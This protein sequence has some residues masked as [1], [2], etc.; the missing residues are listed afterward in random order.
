M[1]TSRILAAGMLFLILTSFKSDKLPKTFQKLLDRAGMMF[2]MPE[3]FEETKPIDNVQMNY[4]YALK[5]PGKKLEVRYAVRP[6][7]NF[8]KEYEEFQE[9]KKEGDMMISPNK[10]YNSLMQATL[11]NISGGQLPQI[12]PFDKDAVKEEFNADWGATAFV[13][14]EKEFGQDYQFCLMVALHKD[15]LG[16][17]YYFFLSDTKEGFEELMAGSFHSL[18]FKP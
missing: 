8:M 13:P 7:D 11:M 10:L 15:N 1:K 5:I 9:N 4:E 2:E 18:K 14:L 6:M 16:D 3:G 17:A 12:D